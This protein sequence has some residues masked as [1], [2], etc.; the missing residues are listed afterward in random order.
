MTRFSEPVTLKTRDNIPP[1]LKFYRSTID[2]VED[3]LLVKVEKILRILEDEEKKNLDLKVRL[4]KKAEEIRNVRDRI[5][6][7]N[8][9]NR[10]LKQ[11]VSELN[12]YI[13]SLTRSLDSISQR[14]LESVELSVDLLSALQYN[15]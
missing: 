9:E 11:E 6:Q 10:S 15:S 1:H 13:L 7:K 14:H 2:R 8:R 12:E 3:R 4:K 5:D